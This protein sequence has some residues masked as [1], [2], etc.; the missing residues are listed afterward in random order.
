MIRNIVTALAVAVMSSCASPP[1]PPSPPSTV[2][3]PRTSSTPPSPR[4]AS[5][6]KPGPTADMSKQLGG[7]RLGMTLEEFVATC[8]Q[9]NGQADRVDGLDFGCSVAP[10]P[11]RVTGGVPVDLSG[12][13]FGKFCGPDATVCELVY[14][15][16]GVAA[17][18]DAQIAAL[19]DMLES[20]YGKAPMTEGY[21][22]RDPMRECVR[23]RN[24]HFKRGWLFTPK[25][26][27]PHPPGWA[28]LVF[29][30]D[31]R[32]PEALNTLTLFYDDGEGIMFRMGE[33]EDGKA[34]F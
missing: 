9:A 21:E 23:T 18:R 33:H 20:K 6:E 17:H 12:Y 26:T 7:M 29:D 2:A 10:M 16:R 13:V 5:E 28:R 4:N 24:V 8:R 15:V 19:L 30:C 3:S 34:N 22:G 1:P 27:P 25:Q 14:M 11:L 32:T 31:L